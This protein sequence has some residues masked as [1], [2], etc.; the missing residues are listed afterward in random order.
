MVAGRI[1]CTLLLLLFSTQSFAQY[2]SVR[3]HEFTNATSDDLTHID[4]ALRLIEEVVNLESFRGEIAKRKF[5]QTKMKGPEVLASILKAH[6]FYASA[7][8]G[9][10][11]L[12]LDM[13]EENS[14]TVGYTSPKDPFMHLNRF[15]HRNYSAAETAGNIFHEWLHKIGHTHTKWNWK[16]RENS[17]PYAL[18]YRLAELASAKEG[19]PIKSHLLK[20][21]LTKKLEFCRH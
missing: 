3:L 1:L 18:G 6:E 17:V 11:D 20:E 9:V 16:N 21:A 14:S 4:N 13:F 2:L 15:F 5:S 12:N 10:I 19:D 8:E 7:G